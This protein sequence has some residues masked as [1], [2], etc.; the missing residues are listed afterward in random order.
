MIAIK[1]VE[2]CEYRRTRIYRG[3]LRT[4]PG[5][6]VVYF[7]ALRLRGGDVAVEAE[8]VL[9]IVAIFQSDEALEVL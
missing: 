8:D 4:A 7:L 1:K 9:W 5:V 3:P 2:E 6:P